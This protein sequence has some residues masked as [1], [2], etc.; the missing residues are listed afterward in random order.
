M[1]NSSEISFAINRK[2]PKN[3]YRSSVESKNID[4]G[5][6]IQ[7]MKKIIEE[8]IKRNYSH[9]L[10]ESQ[11]EIEEESE[12]EG[13]G[14]AEGERE[15]EAEN[16]AEGEREAEAEGEQNS[17]IEEDLDEEEEEKKSQRNPIDAGAQG[18]G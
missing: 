9:N 7:E 1:R 13:E 11:S 10:A 15:A 5:V 12:A 2:I 18:D 6:D 3:A 14:E 4:R 16:E 17:Q 8:Q